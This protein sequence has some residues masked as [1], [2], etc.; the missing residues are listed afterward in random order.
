MLYMTVLSAVRYNPEIK[1]FYEN[2]TARGKV[3]KVAM[4]ACMRKLITIINAI[5]RDGEKKQ[6]S[7]VPNCDRNIYLVKN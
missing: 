4:T 5:I 7:V 3:F 1:A 6:S 2:L